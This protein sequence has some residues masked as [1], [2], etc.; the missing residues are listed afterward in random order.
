ML[1]HLES[2]SQILVNVTS[3]DDFCHPLALSLPLALAHDSFKE[4]SRLLLALRV[5]RFHCR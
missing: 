2:L 3:R 1:T 4:A 5:G